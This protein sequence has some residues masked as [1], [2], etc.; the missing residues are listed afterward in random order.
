[1]YLRRKEISMILIERLRC[2]GEPTH[3]FVH[4]DPKQEVTNIADI[5]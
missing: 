5:I 1:M 2:R 4:L 3:F